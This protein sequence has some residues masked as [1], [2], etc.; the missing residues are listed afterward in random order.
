MKQGEE[1]ELVIEMKEG[2]RK[3]LSDLFS[4]HQWLI[5]PAKLG[6]YKPLCV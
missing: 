1:E 4:I 6:R 2:R 3:P 5:A